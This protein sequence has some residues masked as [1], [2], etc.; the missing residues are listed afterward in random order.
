MWVGEEVGSLLANIL[1]HKLLQC[2]SITMCATFD[3]LKR[4]EGEVRFPH[5]PYVERKD[6]Q[7]ICLSLAR[8][9]RGLL[10]LAKPII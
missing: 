4:R 10:E 2:N 5:F 8:L 9:K 1:L 3:T 6:R 7:S